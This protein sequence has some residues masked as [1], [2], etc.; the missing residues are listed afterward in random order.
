MTCIPWRPVLKQAAVSADIIWRPHL[1]HSGR[2]NSFAFNP[3]PP[4][5]LRNPVYPRAAP[6]LPFR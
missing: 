1:T 2:G 6:S 5:S 4:I 3:R